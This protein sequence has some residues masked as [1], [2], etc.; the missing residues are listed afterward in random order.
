M[1]WWGGE[2]TRHQA[3]HQRGLNSRIDCVVDARKKAQHWQI[4]ELR[5]FF[6]FLSDRSWRL[7]VTAAV[8]SLFYRS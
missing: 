4:R 1:G 6:I 5:S 7:E 3:D 2:G 8:V